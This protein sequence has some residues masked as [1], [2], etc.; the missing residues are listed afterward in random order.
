MYKSVLLRRVLEK[1]FKRRV[2]IVRDL[3]KTKVAICANARW[4]NGYGYGKRHY[5]CDRKG[6]TCSPSNS[7]TRSPQSSLKALTPRLSLCRHVQYCSFALVSKTTICAKTSI[8]KA[9]F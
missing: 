4:R 8:K 5:C 1:G 9:P 7:I 6:D 2:L 3:L